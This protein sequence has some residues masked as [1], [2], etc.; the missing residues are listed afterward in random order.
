M[1]GADEAFVRKL[2]EDVQADRTQTG[3]D[4]QSTM[5][6]L[7]IVSAVILGVDTARRIFHVESIIQDPNVQELIRE[8]EDKGH[9]KGRTEGHTEGRTEG[10]A[11]GRTEGRAAEARLLL[12]KVLAARS[13]AVPSDIR[14]RI[15]AESDVSRLESWLEAAVT[16]SSIADVFRDR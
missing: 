6:L 16:A 14:M 8:W 4:R 13:F 12:H 1:Q 7:Y 9:A 5:Q 15:D 11:E 2:A 3:R 10:R